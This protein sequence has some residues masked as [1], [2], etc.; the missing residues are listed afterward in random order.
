MK[1]G[2]GGC[3]L[4]VFGKHWMISRHDSYTPNISHI[5]CV[6]VCVCVCV[7]GGGVMRC[8]YPSVCVSTLGSYEMGHHK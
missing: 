8:V 2:G 4:C 6:Y 3:I 1:L 7:G 5:V